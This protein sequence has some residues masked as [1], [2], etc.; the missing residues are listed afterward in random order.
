MGDAPCQGAWGARLRTPSQG[1]P[2]SRK[3]DSD[4]RRRAAAQSRNPHARTKRLVSREPEDEGTPPP[5]PRGR[6]RPHTS[7]A[8]GGRK[9]L[10]STIRRRR[11]GAGKGTSRNTKGGWGTRKGQGAPPAKPA[12][13]GTQRGSQAS[14]VPHPPA[15]SPQRG[16]LQPVPGTAGSGLEVRPRPSPPSPARAPVHGRGGGGGA[17]LAEPVP[18]HSLT[19]S[20]R[21][22]PEV[23]RLC[24]DA[25]QSPGASSALPRS[26]PPVPATPNTSCNEHLVLR[27]RSHQAGSRP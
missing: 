13:K 21:T 14:P 4:P 1:P 24:S 20:P 8:L 18:P 10:I 7:S 11:E 16:Q 3:R 23:A 19:W 17:G 27:G 6:G 5:P 2:P 9:D 25:S 12:E 15:D 26:A 22:G